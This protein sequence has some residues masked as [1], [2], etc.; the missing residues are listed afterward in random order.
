MAPFLAQPADV[1]SWYE[2]GTEVLRN[3]QLLSTFLVPYQYSYFLFVFPATALFQDIPKFA[4]IDPISMASL[5]PRLIPQ[6]PIGVTVVPGLLFDFLVKLPLILSDSIIALLLYKILLVSGK[7]TRLASSVAALWFLNPIVIWVSSGWG[8]LDTLPTLFTVLALYFIQTRRYT[9][10]AVSIVIASVL[11][12]YALFLIIP[13]LI[14]AWKMGGKKAFLTNVGFTAATA[15][16]LSL[17]NLTQTLTAV[18]DVTGLS[19]PGDLHYSGLSFWTAITLF[20]PRF[21]PTIPSAVIIASATVAFYIWNARR[22]RPFE[23]ESLAG[24]FAIPILVLLLAFAFVGENFIVWVIPFLALLSREVAVRRGALLL[25]VLAFFSSIT[26]SLLPYYLLP[27][28]PWIGNY[29]V[30]LLSVASPYRVA[31][32]GAVVGGLT[33]GKL[34]LAAFGVGAAL[35]ILGVIVAVILSMKREER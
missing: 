22:A 9:A 20:V 28:A 24:M 13:L 18:A 33:T 30:M 3:P 7:D 2:Y 8:M 23:I 25:S 21:N 6:N 34:I 14:S 12:Y 15:L 17:P 4:A 27:L 10:S 1:F 19:V 11:K 26:N 32:S 5:D 31:P 35:L 16:V 29:L